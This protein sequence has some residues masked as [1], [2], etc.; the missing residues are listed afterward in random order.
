MLEWEGGTK[1][2]PV[3]LLLPACPDNLEDIARI[4][5]PT[6]FDAQCAQLYSKNKWI[7]Y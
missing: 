1:M 4:V 7:A 3:L 5:E 6:C 2:L